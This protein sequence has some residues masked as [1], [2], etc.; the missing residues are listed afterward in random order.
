MPPAGQTEWLLPSHIY[1][2]LMLSMKEKMSLSLVGLTGSKLV[3]RKLQIIVPVRQTRWRC[4]N[5][6]TV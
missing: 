4:I 5:N 3:R 2:F 1:I 6:Q